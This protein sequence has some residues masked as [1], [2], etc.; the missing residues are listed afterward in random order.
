MVI[1]MFIDTHCHLLKED[2]DNIEEIIE[3]MEGNIMIVSGCDEK[4]NQ[5]V[6]NLIDK[7]PNIYGTIGFHPDEANH[8]TK[9][10]L[11]NLEISLNNPKIV[12]VGEI[13][14]DYHWNSNKEA[15]ISLFENQ[16][17]LARKYHLPIVI[18][19]RDAISD[20]YDVMVK[21]NVSNMKSVMHCYSSSV[22]MAKKF[23]E[24]GTLLG[25][26][27]VVTFK[28]GT[29]LKEVVKEID[30]KYL[31]L[32]TD[33]PYLTPEPYRGQKN[34]PSNCIYVAKKISEIKKIS[35]E[36]VLKTTTENAFGQF[37]LKK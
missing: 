6:I 22:E 7:Y 25:I 14:L 20:T 30:L 35:L 18:H 12:G 24:L 28:N 15:Q 34:K 4:S 2:Y 8:I 17:D 27:G 29:K 10:D 3:E 19:S 9:K 36:N 37:D 16:I 32:E 13:G 31:L 5:Q 21:K 26:G 33:S 23:I 11:E 1:V